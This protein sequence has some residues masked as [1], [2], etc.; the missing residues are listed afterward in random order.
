M[1]SATLS[2]SYESV[3]IICVLLNKLSVVLCL[4][5]G[6]DILTGF[7]SHATDLYDGCALSGCDVSRQT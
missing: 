1:H 2:A 5:S 3:N 6:A 7:Y 4:F